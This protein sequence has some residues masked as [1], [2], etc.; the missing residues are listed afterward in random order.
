MKK[1]KAKRGNRRP[2]SET[3]PKVKVPPAICLNN[4]HEHVRD[5]ITQTEVL[6][7]NLK[8]LDRF[9]GNMWMDNLGFMGMRPPATI[10]T[11]WARHVP[12]SLVG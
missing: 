10:E 5:L 4:A 7:Q 12:N 11:K 8:T 6:L 1:N 2:E 3:E 9:F